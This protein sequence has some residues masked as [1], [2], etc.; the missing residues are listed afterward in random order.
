MNFFYLILQKTN[1]IEET[2]DISIVG[3]KVLQTALP[4]ELGS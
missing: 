4:Y 3:G 2:R 1:L